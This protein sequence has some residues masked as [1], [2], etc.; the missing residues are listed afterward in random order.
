MSVI[1][2]HDT[3]EVKK[4][5]IANIHLSTLLQHINIHH[6]KKLYYTTCQNTLY[7]FFIVYKT[8]LKKYV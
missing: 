3:L 6:I 1:Y 7:G 4:K 5:N 8:A 2:D